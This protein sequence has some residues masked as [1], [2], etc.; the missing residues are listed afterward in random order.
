[1]VDPGK[2]TNKGQSNPESSRPCHEDKLLVAPPL[3]DI[4]SVDQEIDSFNNST[5]LGER[6]DTSEGNEDLQL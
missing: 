2:K 3:F 5:A 6:L 1:M 4:G